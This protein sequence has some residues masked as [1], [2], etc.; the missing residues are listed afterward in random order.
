MSNTLVKDITL[1]DSLGNS[2]RIEL[3]HT[4]V[5]QFELLTHRFNDATPL[6]FVGPLGIC[7]NK[8]EHWLAARKAEG[9]SEREPIQNT[10]A[11]RA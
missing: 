7:I 3:H 10:E 6:R 1:W 11:W 9:F 8:G 4:G 5:E 2:C